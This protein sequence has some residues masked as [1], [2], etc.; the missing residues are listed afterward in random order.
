MTV[1]CIHCSHSFDYEAPSFTEPG[2]STVCPS[3]GRD[4]PAEETWGGDS[5]L[6]IVGGTDNRVYCFN[7]GK[8]MTPREGELIPVCE[9]CRAEQGTPQPGMGGEAPLGDEPVADWMIRKA[10]GNVY[11]PFPTET[12]VEWIQARKINADEEVAHIG[13]AW[14]IFGQ[15][16]EFSKYFEKPKSRAPAG[17][18]TDIDFRRRT[19]VR[20]ALTRFGGGLVALVLVG[21]VGFGVW[22]AVTNRALVV[23]E[24]TLEKVADRVG[25][26]G[27]AK[28]P[29]TQGISVD[30]RNLLLE[31]HDKHEGVVGNSMEL[32]L[33]GRTLML[34]DNYDNLIEARDQL[35]KA[36]ALDPDNAL[37]LAGLSEVYN[38]LAWTG[39]GSLDLQR[40]SIYLIQMAKSSGN[41]PAAVLRSEAA[42]LIYS[43]N[44]AEGR[45]KAEEALAKNPEDPS[46]HYLLGVAAMGGG[47]EVT[48]KVQEHFDK[49]IELDPN[50]HQVWFALARAEEETGHLGKAVDYYKKKIATDAESAA[51]HTRLGHIFGSVGRYELAAEH[52]DSA[53][54]LNKREKEAFLERAVLAYQV[55]GDGATAVR[56]LERLLGED[57]PELRIAERKEIGTHLAAAYRLAGQPEK[58]IEAAETV[59]ASDKTYGAAH[60]QLGLALVDAGRPTDAL[61]EFS[62]AEDS[63]LEPPDIARVLFYAGYA[64]MKGDR[65]QDAVESFQRGVDT[66]PS[67]TPLWLWRAKVN[68]E[69]SDPK[70]AAAGMFEHIKTD[71]LRYARDREMGEWWAPVPS[72]QEVADVFAK[73]VE[74]ENFAPALNGALGIALF[75]A[76]KYDSASRYL[77]EAIR[78]DPRAGAPI[79]YEGLI[80]H[81]EGRASSAE[82]LFEQVM[83]VSAL[84]SNA[85]FLIY[86]GD[87]QLAQGKVDDA[88]GSFERGMAYGGTDS[89]ALT[90][91]A[92][93]LSKA[94]RIDDARAKLEAAADADPRA[95]L[96][97]RARYDIPS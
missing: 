7:C 42:F 70:A 53:I 1:T 37:A 45:A 57:G 47:S 60:F 20:D 31:L 93:A 11:G 49:A 10:N 66:D 15:H 72:A 82:Q 5:G 51:S 2:G 32:Y 14:R 33:R 76:G 74:G 26:L 36:V 25:D 54:D 28:A 79:F 43:G 22:Y 35:E 44:Y 52:Y 86:L 73:A 91:Q 80:A 16:E 75:H 62:K 40:E 27:G 56:L 94:G 67:F 83:G 21:G 63:G 78:Q 59:L 68:A 30:A 41:Y 3:C 61:P 19:P 6:N 23:P 17:P 8:G 18:S 96:P 90:R 95:V 24:E 81:Q 29:P 48:D 89:W 64:A 71:P 69:Q 13:G 92:A 38:L 87:A 88:L 50:F 84:G 85:T 9:E 34:R 58:A 4:T 65:A 46:L 77:K 12:I 39:Y 55:E 97:R